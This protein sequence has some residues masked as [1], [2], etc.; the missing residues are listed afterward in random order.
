MVSI[1]I[2]LFFIVFLFYIVFLYLKILKYFFKKNKEG[3]PSLLDFLKKIT[4]S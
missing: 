2:F 4:L 1:F 3:F